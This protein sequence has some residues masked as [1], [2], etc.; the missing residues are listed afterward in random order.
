VKRLLLLRHAHAEAAQG[1]ADID[2]PLSPRGR[3]EA[4]DAA[5][6]IALAELACDAVLSSPAVRARE[7]AVIVATQL[8]LVEALKFEPALYLGS[9][10]A[11][12]GPL[13]RSADSLNTVL[14]VG[15]NPGLSEL[16]QSFNGTAARVDM[17]TAGLCA[18]TFAVR[19]RWRELSPRLTTGVTL[20]R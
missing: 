9:P 4:L 8:D 19:M 10:E 16:A 3:A 18:I 17:R 11:L 1:L 13:R 6:S 5:Q 14:V 15:H 20:L 12:L 7:T 2:R